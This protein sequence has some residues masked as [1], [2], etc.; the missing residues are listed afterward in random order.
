MPPLN[1]ES[2]ILDNLL[3]LEC[4]DELGEFAWESDRQIGLNLEKS[5]DEEESNF[6]SSFVAGIIVEEDCENENE[7]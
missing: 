5:I 6:D 2:I 7:M 4:V 3:E 1:R